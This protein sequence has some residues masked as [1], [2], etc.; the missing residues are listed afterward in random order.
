MATTT[1]QAKLTEIRASLLSGDHKKVDVIIQ[2]VERVLEILGVVTG[3]EKL[4]GLAEELVSLGEVALA[5]YEN[6]GKIE[7]TPENVEALFVTKKLKD[8]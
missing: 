7:I 3:Q 5:K 1:P 6:A 8:E 4:V 2:D